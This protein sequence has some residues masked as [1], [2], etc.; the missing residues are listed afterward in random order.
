[1]NSEKILSIIAIVISLLSFILFCRAENRTDRLFQAQK[2]SDIQVT[3]TSF[4]TF[5]R[6]E[7][8][9]ESMAR[10]NLSIINYTGF[11]ASDVRVDANFS[12][13]W[14]HEW[15][16][17]AAEGLEKMKS[18]GEPLTKDLEAQ[19]NQY[20]RNASISSAFD[21]EP[22]DVKRKEFTGTF[23]YR[24]DKE[25]VLKIRVSW[26][27]ENKAPFDKFFSFKIELTEAYGIQSLIAIP[28]TN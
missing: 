25:N 11:R 13:S 22:G 14:I 28:I 8:S 26:E 1:M 9:N 12:G 17:V 7:P 16:A 18:D 3:P 10:L 24:S 5:I 20:K 15:I 6:A 2:M 27:S 4:T 23:K 21:M 19:L